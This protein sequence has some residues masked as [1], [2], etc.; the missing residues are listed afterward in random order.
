MTS[1]LFKTSLLLFLGCLLFSCTSKKNI[2]YLQDI[3]TAVDPGRAL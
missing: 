2:S 3:D 1:I